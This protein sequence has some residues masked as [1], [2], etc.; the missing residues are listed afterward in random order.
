[1]LDYIRSILSLIFS[2]S[3]MYMLLDCE[4]KYKQNRYQIGF[5]AAILI[6]C[7][8]FVLLHYGYAFFMKL[9]PLLVHLPVFLIFVFISNFKTSKVFFILFTL[10]AVSTS[11]SMVSLSIVFLFSRSKDIANIISYTL[12]L[13]TW[14]MIYKYIR[15]PFLYMLRNSDK[16]WLGFSIIPISYSVLIYSIGMYNIND[17][18]NKFDVKYGVLLFIMVCS[19]YFLILR[20]FK[21]TREQFILQ[22]EQNLLMN[23]IATAKLHFEALEESQE[24]TV[25]YRH[26][27]R[28][29][30]NLIH[31]YLADNNK[32]AALNYISEVEITIKD[33]EVENYCSNYTINLILYSYITDAKKEQIKVET[34]IDLPEQNIVSDMDLCVILGNVIENAINAC[35]DILNINDRSLKIVCKNKNNKLFIQIKNSYEGNV[36]FSDGLP[37][38]TQEH[39][40]LGTKSVASI[41]QKYGG[42]YSFTAENGS[43]TTSIIL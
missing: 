18:V 6:I 19:V 39:H 33:V 38:S 30:L 20:F 34:H 35:K 11:F 4:S 8:G 15:P 29:H 27:M 26:D 42:V 5:F 2:I 41:V 13:P 17:V 23:Q 24:K 37:I 3:V 12:Y 21:Q 28:H 32:K 43:F 7:H 16:G 1:M 25:R 22:N 31:S 10:I 9:Y 40:G 36:T 14:F